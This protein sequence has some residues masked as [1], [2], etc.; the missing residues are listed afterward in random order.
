[1]TPIN[2]EYYFK[3]LLMMNQMG[4]YITAADGHNWIELDEEC[5]YHVDFER[6]DLNN[7]I[8]GGVL[9]AIDTFDDALMADGQDTLMK[10]WEEYGKDQFRFSKVGPDPSRIEEVDKGKG[11]IF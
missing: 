2:F 3:R 5:D 6:I 1:M 8:Y 10:R 11:G 9:Q 7:K 4:I